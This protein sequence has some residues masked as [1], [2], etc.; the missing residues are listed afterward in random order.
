M[1]QLRHCF[2]TAAVTVPVRMMAPKRAMYNHAQPY[3]IAIASTGGQSLAIPELLWVQHLPQVDDA[4][5]QEHRHGSKH[6]QPH[7]VLILQ[8]QDS[9]PLLLVSQI[10]QTSSKQAG[11]VDLSLNNFQHIG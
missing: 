9:N 3:A 2:G 1:W 8:A 6:H 11:G 7:T 10:S 4:H 5:H